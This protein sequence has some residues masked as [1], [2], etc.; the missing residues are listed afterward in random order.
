MMSRAVRSSAARTTSDGLSGFM[1]STTVNSPLGCSTEM[2]LL[3]PGGTTAQRC[4]TLP[5]ST[6]AVATVTY[7]PQVGRVG[8]LNVAVAAAIALA[9]V[10][11]REWTTRPT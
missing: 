10:R 5:G 11:R 1:P 7:I 2:L 3:R 4:A 8:S 9:E 6:A